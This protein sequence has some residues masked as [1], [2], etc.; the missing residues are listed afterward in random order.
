MIRYLIIVTIVA[1]VGSFLAGR[2]GH[3][4]AVWFAICA[5]IPVFIIVVLLLPTRIVVPG[6]TK[7]CPF[8]AEIIREDAVYCRQC[9]RD[10][11]HFK[12][13]DL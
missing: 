8:C 4:R 2:K 13:G 11:G 5:I 7:K 10:I 6:L 1:V 12:S 9:H 3:N